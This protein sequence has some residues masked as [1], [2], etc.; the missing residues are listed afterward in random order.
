[1]TSVC[2]FCWKT[3]WE[4]IGRIIFLA[5][6]SSKR[7]AR[8]QARFPGTKPARKEWTQTVCVHCLLTGFWPRFRTRKWGHALGHVIHESLDAYGTVCPARFKLSWFCV[9]PCVHVNECLCCL[10]LCIS[11]GD[12]CSVLFFVEVK[13]VARGL[14]H[15]FNM[16]AVCPVMLWDVG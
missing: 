9:L 1:M 16:Q 13:C 11:G 6:N 14:S 4:Q 5:W 2:V 7:R 8:K 15:D 10:G 12:A 3:Q